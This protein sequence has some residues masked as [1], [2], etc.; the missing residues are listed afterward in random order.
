MHL[1]HFKYTNASVLRSFLMLLES[2]IL[3]TL[4]WNSSRLNSPFT[5][6][7][8][9]KNHNTNS[10]SCESYSL[11]TLQS[12]INN[13]IFFIYIYIYWSRKISLYLVQSFFYGIVSPIIYNY[14]YIVRSYLYS[15]FPPKK[16]ILYSFWAK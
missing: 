3:F 6:H 12:F 8:L 7:N 10:L 15:F 16:K 14:I 2:L 4:F 5:P 9:D 13:Q 1:N 11:Q